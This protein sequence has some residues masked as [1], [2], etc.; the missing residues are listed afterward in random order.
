MLD[1]FLYE[2]GSSEIKSVTTSY[3]CKL[4]V[5]AELDLKASTWRPRL[6]EDNI[7]ACKT[8]IIRG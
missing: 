3:V 5:N 7:T 8:E 1:K 2:V 4:E 6:S